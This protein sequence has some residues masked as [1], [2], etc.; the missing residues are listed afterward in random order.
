MVLTGNEACGKGALKVKDIEP[1]GNPRLPVTAPGLPI[2]LDSPGYQ[3]SFV[4]RTVDVRVPRQAL[5]E[6]GA[7]SFDGVTADLQ[8]NEQ[9]KNPLLCVVKVHDIA[10]GDLSLPAKLN[11][12]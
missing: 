7:F 9:G 12:D 11:L 2:L 3:I 8:I 5:A 4:G 1:G 6:A 10:S